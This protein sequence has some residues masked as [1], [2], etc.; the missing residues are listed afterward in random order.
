[1]LM[2]NLVPPIMCFELSRE[3]NRLV[4]RIKIK[5]VA[6]KQTSEMVTGATLRAGVF[7]L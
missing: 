1:M 7:M 2:I 6:K 5:R 4:R 3:E